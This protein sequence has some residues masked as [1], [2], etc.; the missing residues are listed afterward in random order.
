MKRCPEKSQAC[1]CMLCTGK[2]PVTPNVMEV[3]ENKSNF[4]LV[5][6]GIRCIL[7]EQIHK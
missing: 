7:T 5:Y 1:T 6:L 2:I 4:M 3:L